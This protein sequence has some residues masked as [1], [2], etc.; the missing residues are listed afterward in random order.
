MNRKKKWVVFFGLA[1]F[2]VI[3]LLFVYGGRI[4]GDRLF[5]YIQ[6]DNIVRITVQKTVESSSSAEDQG[7]FDLTRSEI[8]R[9]YAVISDS[10]MKGIRGEAFGINTEVRYYVFLYN[11]EG[12]AEGTMKFYGDEELIFDYVY[13][14]RPAIHKRYSIRVSSFEDFFESLFS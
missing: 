7:F 1:A 13:G 3:V 10:E 9:F 14:D 6:V 11:S 2:G 12:Y 8:E 5:D 4:S